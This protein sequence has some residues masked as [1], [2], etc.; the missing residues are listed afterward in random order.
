MP[1][2]APGRKRCDYAPGWDDRTR[3]PDRGDRTENPS[4]PE[5]H[6]APAAD[7]R[8]KTCGKCSNPGARMGKLLDL[9]ARGAFF[10]RQLHFSVDVFR[11]DGALHGAFHPVTIHL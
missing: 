10:A 4:A 2:G 11:I 5:R 9:T 1:R 6:R 8:I 3:R 7:P